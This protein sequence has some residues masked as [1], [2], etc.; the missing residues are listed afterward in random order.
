MFND[1]FYCSPAAG[2]CPDRLDTLLSN[3]RE[4]QASITS[5]CIWKC[6]RNRRKNYWIEVMPWRS[7]PL[8]SKLREV[9]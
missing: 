1:E 6:G 4:S 3:L 5:A 8:M 9:K 2:N 7:F